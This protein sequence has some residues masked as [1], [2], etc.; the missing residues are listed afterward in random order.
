MATYA[1]YRHIELDNIGYGKKRVLKPPGG[2]SSDIFGS[3]EPPA[4]H[5][6]RKTRTYDQTPSGTAMNGTKSPTDSTPSSAASST[7]FPFYLSNSAR[8]RFTASRNPVTGAGFL[9]H[10]YRRTPRRKAFR[11]YYGNPVTG[12]GYEPTQ[13]KETR[14]TTSA[15]ASDLKPRQRVPPGGFS[16]GLW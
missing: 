4:S 3:P 16:S 6:L 8:S 9:W 15:P 5:S 1:A 14:T 11:M 13:V 12:D 10:D 2:G 7:D